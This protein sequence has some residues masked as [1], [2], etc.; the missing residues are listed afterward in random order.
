MIC[1]CDVVGSPKAQ[2]NF[3]QYMLADT[4]IKEFSY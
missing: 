4:E 3:I 1:K 2:E